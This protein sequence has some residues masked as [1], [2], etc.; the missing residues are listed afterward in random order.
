MTSASPFRGNRGGPRAPGRPDSGVDS[1]PR[2]NPEL[3]AGNLAATAAT[4]AQAAPSNIAVSRSAHT[5]PCSA[6]FAGVGTPARAE[7]GLV[8]PAIVPRPR[9]ETFTVLVV[10]DHPPLRQA[11]SAWLRTM[12]AG[13]VY[14]AGS[15]AQARTHAH[16]SGPCD[17][18]LLDV[19]LPDGS[20]LELVTELRA[21]GW[22]RLV[23]LASSD[24]P[25]AA[26][27]AFRAGAQAYLRK[28]APAA[29]ITN[30]VQ[31]VLDSG[32]HAG[33]AAGPLLATATRVPATDNTLKNLST[34]EVEVL[35]LI[36]GG[37]TN[38]EIGK[39]LHLSAL[40]IK[41]HLNRIGRKLGTGDR[42]R[43]VTLALRAGA[44]Q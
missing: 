16:T 3:P 43:M 12:G 28:S 9:G 30:G 36:A 17:L 19:G 4:A 14:E 21:L 23:V 31:H 1:D 26:R 18:A 25:D 42:A 33:P 38:K 41:S 44:I 10:D 8:P 20:G 32:V 13:T 37:Q 2:L 27:S 7:G 11:V 6:R 24:D 40:T 39:A 29:L 5:A 35:H 22:T 34:R 15:I